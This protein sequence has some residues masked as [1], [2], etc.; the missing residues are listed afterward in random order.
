MDTSLFCPEC[1][2]LLDLPGDEEFVLCVVCGARQSAKRTCKLYVALISN[3]LFLVFEDKP[4][5]T[6]SRKDVFGGVEE[7]EHKKSHKKHSHQHHG[8]NH[9]ATI[10]E[11]C[12]KCGNPEMTF[13]T[14]QLRSADEGQT[15]FYTCPKC[16]YKYS[17]NT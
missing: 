9:G 6:H 1:H 17:V 7:D 12:P 8:G 14:M 2:N 11:R 16:S 4:F 5:V 10:K 3:F 13:Q 15:V